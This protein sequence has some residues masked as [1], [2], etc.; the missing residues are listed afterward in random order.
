MR[1]SLPKRSTSPGR[2][3]WGVVA[4]CALVVVAEGY[5]LIVFGALLPSL[6]TEAGW[7][8]DAASAGTIGSLVY[9]GMLVGALAGGRLCD[10][11]GRR[12]LVIGAT[13]WFG[14]WTLACALAGGP[15]QLG[16]FRL[17]A[18]IGM[19]AVMPAALAMAKEHTPEGRSALTVTILMA[20]VP[21]GGTAAS[22]LALEVLPDHGWRPMFALG[23]GLSAI[24]FV[25]VLALMPES[26]DFTGATTAADSRMADLFGR[27]Y[28]AQTVL[29]ALA[30]FTNLLTWYGLN[31]WL[32]TLMRELDYPLSSALQ[33]SLTLN[34]G[35]VVGSFAV[36]AAADR[37]GTRQIAILCAL[38]SAA[39]VLACAIGTDSRGLLLGFIAVMGLSAHSGLNLINAAVGDS[40]PAALRGTALGWSNGVGRLGA[41][42]APMLGGWLLAA[43]LG[44][45]S[46]FVAFL[47]SA[48]LSAAVL[49]ALVVLERNSTRH[50][51]PGRAGRGGRQHGMTTR[52]SP[53]MYHP[54][55]RESA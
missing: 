53:S 52:D 17:L 16:A 44:A 43:E 25:A 28:L 31:T 30:A 6:L 8:L 27:R 45:R 1:P 51:G 40:Y 21:I 20:G 15:W 7:G 54:R 55:R 46:V 2:T 37:W 4:L 39:G 49:A 35:A 14:A 23:A 26:R 10:R 24:V 50:L 12:P 18:G 29:F 19:G 13:A 36:A 48:L 38:L 11:L 34:I 33:F 32:T 47:V 9:I 42:L 3:S 22:L 5:D 41:V